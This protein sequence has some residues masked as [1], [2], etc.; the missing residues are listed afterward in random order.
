MVQGERCRVEGA[1]RR[2][3]YGTGRRAKGNSIGIN[4]RIGVI[5]RG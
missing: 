1:K 5:G 4:L 2:K 3:A